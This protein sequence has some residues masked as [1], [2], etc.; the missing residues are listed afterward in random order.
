MQSGLRTQS[1]PMRFSVDFDGTVPE[2]SCAVSFD[3]DSLTANITPACYAVDEDG[4]V[5]NTLQEGVTLSVYRID[6]DGSLILLDDNIPN[7]GSYELTDPHASFDECWYR[8]VA[9]DTATGMSNFVDGYDDSP[10][11]LCVIQWDETWNKLSEEDAEGDASYDYAGSRLDGLYN[12]DFSE[13]ASVQ[14]EDIEYIGREHPVSYYGTQKGYTARYQTSFPKTDGGTLALVRKLMAWRDDV[15]IRE[16]SGT[17]FWAHITNADLSRS[18]EGGAINF[19]ISATRVDRTD[20][21]LR[22]E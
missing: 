22:R 11:S 1:E 12:L 9:T 15:Y 18:A 21:A 13:S 20:N 4:E 19:T 16:S 3:E 5:T 6:E 10:Y 2:P 14:A 8:V 7:V 17:G